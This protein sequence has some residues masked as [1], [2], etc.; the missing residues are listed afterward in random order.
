MKKIIFTFFKFFI[1]IIII[2]MIFILGLGIYFLLSPKISFNMDVIR[3][4][5]LS[6]EIYNNQNLL[7]DEY[8]S[9]NTVKISLDNLQDYTKQAFISIE[10]KDF[11]NHNGISIKR[12]GKAFIKNLSNFQILEGASTISQQLIKNTFYIFWK[13]LLWNRKCKSILFFKKCK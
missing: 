4:N 1:I 10:D 6:I 2:G 11:Y 9:F 12:M 5:N 7:I 8:N 13:Q 3:D